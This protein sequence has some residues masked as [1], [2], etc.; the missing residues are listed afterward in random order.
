MANNRAPWVDKSKPMPR[1]LR[2]R[3]QTRR[4]STWTAW[5]YWRK[6]YA[7][8]PVWLDREGLVFVYTQRA[9]WKAMGYD[10]VVDHIVPLS[11]P[12]VCGLHVPWN[13]QL[14][15][16]A[17]NANKSNRYWPDMPEQQLPMRF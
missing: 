5:K 10:A 2:E 8:Q 7:A 6:I 3:P 4:P 14:L 12:L 1:W 15:S 13:L 17:D 16:D 9:I 11:H